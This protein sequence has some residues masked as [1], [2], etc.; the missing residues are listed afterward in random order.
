MIVYKLVNFPMRTSI[1]MQ[2]PMARIY[3]KDETIKP[4]D[5]RFPLYA[6]NSLENAAHYAY[7]FNDRSI[8]MGTFKILKCKA[9]KSRQKKPNF[10]FIWHW[11]A[12]P[13]PKHILETSQTYQ[14][15]QT[16]IP[17]GTILCSSITPLE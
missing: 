9:V 17:T 13:N 16:S 5:R 11:A 8:K 7:L 1:I 15:Y 14:Q 12:D 2:G 6:F 10:S 4:I 3:T